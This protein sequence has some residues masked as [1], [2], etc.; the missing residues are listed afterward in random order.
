MASPVALRPGN[1]EKPDI[2]DVFQA[3]FQ[4]LLNC[5]V[6]PTVSMIHMTNQRL[7]TKNNNQDSLS[8]C[9]GKYIK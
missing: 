4:A 6:I 1:K 8:N 9:I 5:C 7:L 2:A 3:L